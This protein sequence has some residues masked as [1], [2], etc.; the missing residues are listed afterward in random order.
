MSL[1]ITN[2]IPGEGY[3]D[4]SG[5]PSWGSEPD[6]DDV[7]ADFAKRIADMRDRLWVIGA[8]IAV[9]L[10]LTAS[11]VGFAFWTLAKALELYK[12]L[13]EEADFGDAMLRNREKQVADIA[14]YIARNPKVA[15]RAT[16]EAEDAI[17][18]RNKE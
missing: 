18:K 17:K 11:L 15:E 14:A 3:I 7:F 13:A 2:I 5:N 16:K 6:T 10:L 1:N 4:D 12:E 8:L 9:G